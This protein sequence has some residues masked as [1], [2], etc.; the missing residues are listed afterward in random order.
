M[1]RDARWGVADGANTFLFDSLARAMRCLHRHAGSRLLRGVRIRF[2]RTWTP[3]GIVE[4]DAVVG[5]EYDVIDIDPPGAI[6][7]PAWNGPGS[8]PD[9]P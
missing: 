8:P 5:E 2:T 6:R 1:Q 9:F 4:Q 7:A 3:S